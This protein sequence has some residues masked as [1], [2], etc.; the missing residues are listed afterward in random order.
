M[1]W[2]KTNIIFENS[3]KN[4]V[5]SYV[6]NISEKNIF[7][8][9]KFPVLPLRD[10]R[11]NNDNFFDNSAI[12]WRIILGKITFRPTPLFRTSVAEVCYDLPVKEKKLFVMKFGMTK[13]N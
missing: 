13:F 12:S 9:K 10:G 4:W 3:V 8:W 6:L 11:V 5:D 7:F 1:I 2:F